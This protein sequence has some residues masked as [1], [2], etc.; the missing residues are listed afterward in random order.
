M[1]DL[2]SGD[3][4]A[5]ILA[6]IDPDYGGYEG[7]YRRCSSTKFENTK[8]GDVIEY[9]GMWWIDQYCWRKEERCFFCEQDPEIAAYKVIEVVQ[10]KN[11]VQHKDNHNYL[12]GLVQKIFNDENTD[13][14]IQ[15]QDGTD[16]QVH[17]AVIANTCPAWKRLL[18]FEC[19]ETQESK[20]IVDDVEPKIVKAFVRALYF[21][22]VE[23]SDLLPGV[24]ELS[25]RYQ[26]EKLMKRVG[27]QTLKALERRSPDF[28]FQV[29]KLLHK[30]PGES[31][32]KTELSSAVTQVIMKEK[33]KAK[34]QK[35]L[36]L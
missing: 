15:L 14:V 24:L 9:K 16:I 5:F 8:S 18:A 30:I 6:C 33:K 29:I 23:N 28:C 27:H 34:V 11:N 32:L 22:G 7:Y 2:V 31:E 19:R 35:M 36:G 13:L 1:N 10:Q 25:N 17:K 20:I 12:K 21:G 4:K 3:T 26:A